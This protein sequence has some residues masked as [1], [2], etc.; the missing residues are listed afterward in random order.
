M[1]DAQRLLGVARNFPTLRKVLTD[2]GLFLNEDG[3]IDLNKLAIWGRHASSGEKHAVAF[4]CN[5]YNSRGAWD[6]GTFRFFDAW[7]TW[8]A[9]HRAA[10]RAW[11]AEGWMP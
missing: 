8:D 7:G 9:E 6:C 10:F 5:L 11:A 1:T 3:S 4:V 2:D